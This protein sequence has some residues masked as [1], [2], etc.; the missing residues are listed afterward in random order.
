L[1]LFV[2]D[3]PLLQNVI[4]QWP[5]IRDW[6]IESWK[7][8]ALAITWSGI[9]VVFVRR[10]IEWYRKQFL[11]QVNFSLNYLQEGELVFRTLQETSA[12]D[13]WLS[14][15]G[16]EKVYQAI[17]RTTIEQPF[18]RIKN[19]HDMD[20][21]NRAVL[22]VL[23]E[24]FAEHYLA[25]SLGLP[26]KSQTFRFAIT[27]ERY[28]EIKTLKLRVLIVEE[29]TLHALFGLQGLG[30]KSVQRSIQVRDRLQTLKKMWQQLKLEQNGSASTLGRVEL[31]LPL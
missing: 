25:V 15:V 21:I 24:R 26:V 18:I 30:E 31:G 27:Y 11:G 7:T 23:S 9:I 13:V 2:L 6:L 29:K 20:F 17:R 5:Q 8:I 22:N 12:Q 4:Q 14:E 19:L 1:E 3:W 10:R 16:V 28:R